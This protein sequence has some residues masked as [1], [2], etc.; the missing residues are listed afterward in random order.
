MFFPAQ[1]SK[2]TGADLLTTLMGQLQGLVMKLQGF[3]ENMETEP[4]AAENL[5]EGSE[6]FLELTQ[7]PAVEANKEQVRQS[8][9]FVLDF[10]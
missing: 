6:L 4:A 3:E 2:D 10:M 7:S 1:F 5:Q 9:A 8:S